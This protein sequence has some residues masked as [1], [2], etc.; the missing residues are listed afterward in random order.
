MLLFVGLLVIV[1][2]SFASPHEIRIS[3]ERKR[4]IYLVVFIIRVNLKV[5]FVS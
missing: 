1:V 2:K 5:P 4:G 3:D